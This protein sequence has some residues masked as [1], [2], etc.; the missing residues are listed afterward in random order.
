MPTSHHRDIGIE[1][2]VGIN[3]KPPYVSM[4]ELKV[5]WAHAF[6]WLWHRKMACFCPS[7]HK[8]R[9]NIALFAY[10]F[11]LFC[12]FFILIFTSHVDPIFS[13]IG[14][15]Q[16]VLWNKYWVI[17]HILTHKMTAYSEL[18]FLGMMQN[19]ACAFVLTEQGCVDNDR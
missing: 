12:Q 16:K 17:R 15:F 5:F 11:C 2:S 19:L 13:E 10:N 18:I 6:S 3:N 14:S 9:P 1:T 8:K 4:H 7:W